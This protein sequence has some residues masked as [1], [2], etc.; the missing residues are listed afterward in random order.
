MAMLANPVRGRRETAER[1]RD[2]VIPSRN[3]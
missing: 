1:V 2:E 3:E